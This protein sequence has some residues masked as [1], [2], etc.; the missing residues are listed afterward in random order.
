MSAANMGGQYASEAG[1]F[2][3]AAGQEAR[4]MEQ[5]L[6]DFAAA[7]NRHDPANMAACWAQ[8]GDLINPF[9]RVAKGQDQ[10]EQLFR[11]EQQGPM[12]TCSFQMRVSAVRLASNDIAM[13]DA[14]C[15]LTGIR[16]PDGK[17]QPVFKPH[18][19]F[20]MSKKEGDWKILSAR[21]YAYS[22]MPGRSSQA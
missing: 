18:I 16:S 1:A 21:P 12:K 19:F 6:A 22:P 2:M 20:V 3:G 10:V 11:D 7:W 4:G 14:D 15:T 9:G 17:E 13:A 8:D 5:S